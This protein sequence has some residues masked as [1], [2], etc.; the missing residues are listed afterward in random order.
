MKFQE[1]SYKFLAL[2]LTQ[3]P[4]TDILG[5]EEKSTFMLH[6]RS[7]YRVCKFVGL[8][9]RGMGEIFEIEHNHHSHH[10]VFNNQVAPMLLILNTFNTYS[11][12]HTVKVNL[13]A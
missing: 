9:R 8:T 6:S 12:Y 3:T 7:S 1:L 13:E 2:L 4:L 11:V 10:S 5:P